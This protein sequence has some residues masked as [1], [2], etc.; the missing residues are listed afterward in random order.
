MKRKIAQFDLELEFDPERFDPKD[1][2]QV[3]WYDPKMGTHHDFCEH[4]TS[5]PRSATKLSS[6]SI[7]N[8]TF[9]TRELWTI[10]ASIEY[11]PEHLDIETAQLDVLEFDQISG[12]M[13]ETPKNVRITVRSKTVRDRPNKR[14][15]TTVKRTPE[16]ALKSLLD[17]LGDIYERS[18]E[19]LDTD[20]RE[21]LA[22]A[23][24]K[25]F[26]MPQPD[27]TLPNTFYLDSAEANTG[28]R[29]AL[30]EYTQAAGGF[31][32]DAFHERLAAFQNLDVVAEN[33][34][35]YDEFFGWTNPDEYDADGQP[36]A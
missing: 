20:V 24:W 19:L 3:A 13:L 23:I 34:F 36:K 17:S 2:L 14:K 5:E 33:G 25:L 4:F 29:S 6:D 8:A 11:D 1:Q 27:Y 12:S 15:A 9:P 31:A 10:E 26:L 7:S 18:P 16:D 28:I 21:A 35:T 22:E 30:A 32:L